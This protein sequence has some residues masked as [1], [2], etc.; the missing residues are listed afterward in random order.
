MTG[1]DLF[2]YLVVIYGMVIN[3]CLIVRLRYSFPAVFLIFV[4]YVNL[5]ALSVF[6][7][8]RSPIED[9]LVELRERVRELEAKAS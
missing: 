9:E 6:A 5:L 3:I 2:M 8:R 4:P 1:S 7:F